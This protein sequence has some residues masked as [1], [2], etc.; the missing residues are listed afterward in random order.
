VDYLW[1]ACRLFVD[2]CAQKQINFL[3]TV[4]WRKSLLLH[5]RSGKWAKKKAIWE[6]TYYD[7]EAGWGGAKWD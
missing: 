2:C 5:I 7:R 3:D 4:V 6:L 1:A